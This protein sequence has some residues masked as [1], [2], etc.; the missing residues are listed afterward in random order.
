[1]GFLF[2]FGGSELGLSLVQLRC[3]WFGKMNGGMGIKQIRGGG[4]F[5]ILKNNYC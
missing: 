3:V 1:M 4:G 2:L 5:F